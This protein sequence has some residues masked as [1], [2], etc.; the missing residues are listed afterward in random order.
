VSTLSQGF[1]FNTPEFIQR[2]GVSDLISFPFGSEYPAIYF[3]HRNNLLVSLEKSPFGGFTN[4]SLT[5]SQRNAV[6]EEFLRWAKNNKINSITIRAFP[7]IYNTEESNSI[8][9]V[10]EKNG[11]KVL[12]KDIT[13]VC[14]VDSKAMPI[15][16]DRRR[17]LRTSESMGFNFKKL[18]IK[19]LTEAHSLF[20]QSRNNKG[21]PITMS[22]QDFERS[23][24]MFRDRYLLFGVFDKNKMIAATVA[25][26]VN[27]KLLYCFFI[28]DHL[29]YRTFSPVTILITG[30]YGFAQENK[31]ELID[32]GISTDKGIL[33]E[34]LYQFKKTLGAIDSVKNTYQIT[35]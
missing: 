15:N 12:Y 9:F 22:L 17:R 30:V 19:F 23:F 28:G 35:L 27:E 31:I 5:E 7:Q 21:Y 20:E 4:N 25:I 3:T 13:Q 33:N 29:E 10:L 14:V 1:F 18:P 16:N 26:L 34:G 8:S 11:F 32:L 24:T 6:C 2:N